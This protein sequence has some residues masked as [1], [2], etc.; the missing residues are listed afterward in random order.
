MLKGAFI[1]GVLVSIAILLIV[2]VALR[3]FMLWYWRVN[4]AITK[5]DLIL[6]ELKKTPEKT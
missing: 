4:E 6:T 1:L 2:F 5:L 3:G